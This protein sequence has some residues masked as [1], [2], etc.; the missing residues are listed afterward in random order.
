MLGPIG[1]HPSEGVE[2]PPNGLAHQHLLV[3]GHGLLGGRRAGP[4]QGRHLLVAGDTGSP[5]ARRGQ[6]AAT[7]RCPVH[8]RR[9]RPRKRRESHFVAE[10]GNWTG[11]RVIA[12]RGALPLLRSVKD[13]HHHDTSP[14]CRVR[15]SRWSRPEQSRWDDPDAI[16][17]PVRVGARRDHDRVE[18]L[19][20][21]LVAEPP[22][23]ADVVI[24]DGVGEDLDGEDAMIAAFDDQVDLVLAAM[25]P[26]MPDALQPPG[27]R[28]GRRGSPTTRRADR[29]ASHREVSADLRYPPREA[30]R[31]RRRA[32]G[33]RARG[34]SSGGAVM[35][36]DG[37]GGSTSGATRAA[38][39]GSR[40]VR[41]CRGTSAPSPSLACPARRASRHRG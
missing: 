19:V 21:E 33:R 7:R 36:R 35:S 31:H 23:V 10:T 5:P 38:D 28:R 9:T 24:A 41:E 11:R 25:G 4:G 20:A 13:C 32:D 12:H 37:E 18:Q 26:Q 30:R 29:T 17:S 3:G 14:R 40:A 39:R 22:E 2:A 34:P 8:E 6:A 15:P 1:Q 27:R 16:G